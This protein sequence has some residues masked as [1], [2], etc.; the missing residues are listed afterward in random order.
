MPVNPV[1][2]EV[3]NPPHRQRPCHISQPKNNKR[4]E[5][6]VFEE[7]Q[8]PD[9]RIA[10]RAQTIA[11]LA[12]LISERK[13]GK[14]LRTTLLVQSQRLEALA[15]SRLQVFAGEPDDVASGD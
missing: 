11:S 8:H 15:R 13:V 14:G 12:R 5:V 2:W 10:R 9:V 7:R 4:C 3:Q 6:A 1:Q